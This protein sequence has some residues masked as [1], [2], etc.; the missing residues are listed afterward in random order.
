MIN[1]T[2]SPKI[3]P[4][5]DDEQQGGN[6]DIYGDPDGVIRYCSGPKGT[7]KKDKA[8]AGAP[9]LAVQDIRGRLYGCCNMYGENGE[10]HYVLNAGNGLPVAPCNV[11]KRQCD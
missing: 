7:D 10:C 4:L 9:M 6:A 11:L 5:A 1:Q 8:T 3:R 2:H